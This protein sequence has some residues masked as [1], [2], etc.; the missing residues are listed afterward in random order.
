[1]RHNLIGGLLIFIPCLAGASPFVNI[2]P[3]PELA[4]LRPVTVPAKPETDN[5]AAQRTL[6]RLVLN[7]VPDVL[8]VKKTMPQFADTWDRVRAGFGIPDLNVKEVAESEARYA[9]RP[10]LVS[11]IFERSSYYLFHIVDEIE[12]RGL[13]TELALLPFVESGFDPFALSTAQAAGL[14][15]FIPE[16]ANRYNL[17]Q[18]ASFD[19][20]RDIVASTA[21]A[22]EYLQSLHKQFGDWHLALAAYN[23]GENQVA[24]AIERNR[25]RG[26]PVTYASLPLPPET[27]S[28]VPR[29]LAVKHI[30]VAPSL[31]HIV[32]PSV[33]NQ[34]YFTTVIK[35]AM[36]NVSL[37]ARLAGMSVEEFKALNPAYNLPFINATVAVPFVIPMERAQD[38]SDRLDE[39]LQNEADM[40]RTRTLPSGRQ[41]NTKKS[42]LKKQLQ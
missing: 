36:L 12:K 18:S 7:F 14:W 16:T 24:R 33:P 19:A 1:M 39:H 32:L 31:F 25:A 13:P 35:P 15:Q 41:A 6:P 21:A 4:A 42:N 29:L 23:W 22:L 30:V 17:L 34:P 26:L 37:A 28:Y 38:F 11:R 3:H 8:D 9:A 5:L 20:R 2:T 40:R 10:E 27:R